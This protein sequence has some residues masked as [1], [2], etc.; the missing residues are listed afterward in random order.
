MIRT[1]NSEE[2]FEELKQKEGILFYFSHDECNVCKVLKPKIHD[3][4]SDHFPGVEMY[5]VNVKEL[6]AVAG[7]EAVFAVPTIAVLFDGRE[8]IRKSRNIGL[9]E[10]HQQIQRPYSLLFEN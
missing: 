6:P 1:V 2:E 10:L 8:F 5:Y 7:Q 4:L 3:M 9:Q